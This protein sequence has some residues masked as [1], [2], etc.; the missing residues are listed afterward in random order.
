MARLG[1]WKRI[2]IIVSVAWI[3]G[4]GIYFYNLGVD[5]SVSQASHDCDD[6]DIKADK[7]SYA[8]FEKC[9][10]NNDTHLPPDTWL[11]RDAECNEA[12]RRE[13]ASDA[14]AYEECRN[15]ISNDLPTI[16]A[17]ALKI[18]AFLISVSLAL[19]W[20]FVYLIL[21]LVNWVK[22]GFMRPQ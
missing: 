8:T 13:Q 3:L 1:G 22:R 12:R 5:E 4:A 7:S 2:G 10:R 6:A 14:A 11:A 21:F 17:R 18:S 15:N 19:S 16:R 20:G 9:H